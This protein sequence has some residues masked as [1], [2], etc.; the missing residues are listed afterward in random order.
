MN[1]ENIIDAKSEWLNADGPNSDIVISSRIRLARNIKGYPFPHRGEHNSNIEIMEIILSALKKTGFFKGGF[2]VKM[3][4]LSDLDKQMLLEKHLI[5]KEHLIGQIGSA[6][7]VS[8]NHDLSVMVNE[9][10]HLRLQVLKAGFRLDECWN[11]INSFDSELEKYLDFAFSPNLGYLTSCPT[12][13]GTGM[14]ASV[15]IHLPGLVLMDLINKVMQAV[16]KLGLAV[17]GFYGE[18]S[19]ILGNLF[20]VSNQITLGKKEYEIISSITRVLDLVIEHERNSREMLR[21][22]GEEKLKD[23]IGRAYG[24]LTNAYLISTKETIALLSALRLGMDMEYISGIDKGTINELFILTQPAHLQL[25]TGQ[26]LDPDA[27]DIKRAKLI[28]EKLGTN[29]INDK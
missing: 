1:F 4:D 3:S 22:T 8:K 28:R 19:E 14:R 29:K 25:K 24:I 26:A 20:Q 12:N 7:A 10:D 9:E 16:L 27:R 18:G 17:R 21:K 13:V 5:S 15:M 23:R 11:L 6:V 2:I